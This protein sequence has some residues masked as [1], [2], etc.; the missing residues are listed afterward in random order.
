MNYLYAILSDI[1]ANY[2]AL[3]QVEK[4]AKKVAK[5]VKLDLQFICLGD[6]VDYGPQPNECLDWVR[7][8]V[9][10]VYQLRGNHDD[11][12][13]QDGWARPQRVHEDFHPITL[14]T[15]FTLSRDQRR[16]LREMRESVGGQNGLGDFFFF[17]SSVRGRGI[18]DEI[19][20]PN[21]GE[22]TLNRLHG[23]H[24]YGIFGHSH[25]Q[26][27]WEM[28][29]GRNGR[30][31]ARVTFADP[32]LGSDPAVA[33]ERHLPANNWHPLPDQATLLN[34]GSVGQPR[35]HL[36]QSH[37]TRAAYLLL[38]SSRWGWE[39]QWRR[40]AYDLSETLQRIESLEWP[41]LAD[42]NGGNGHNNLKDG[43]ARPGN[44]IDHTAYV[45]AERE[46]VKR[47]LPDVKGKLSSYLKQG[48][49]R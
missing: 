18:D 41:S 11:D 40:V 22:G 29:R 35:R 10:P 43:G 31:E 38:R 9:L 19:V 13:S 34:A 24:H 46:A 1:H 15:R 37:D 42:A 32:E 47:R 36:C 7:D 17:H 5:Q 20:A 33:N 21:Q 8:N 25:F 14:W 2:Q 23:K 6:I 39:F 4:D 48:G 28:Q 44:G 12:A 16:W 27:L 30:S 26:M 45:N 49:G 3:K